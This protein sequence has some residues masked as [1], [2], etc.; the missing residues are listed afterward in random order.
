MVDGFKMLIDLLIT[1]A[2]CLWIVLF[3]ACYEVCSFDGTEERPFRYWC[4]FVV[5]ISSKIRRHDRAFVTAIVSDTTQPEISST[6]KAVHVVG[7]MGMHQ[8]SWC[9]HGRRIMPSEF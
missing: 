7:L 3:I 4:L 5:Y 9:E 1:V 6:L 8:E 2:V